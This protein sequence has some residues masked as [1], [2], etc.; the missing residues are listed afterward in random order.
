MD[1]KDISALVNSATQQAM[2]TTALTVID[3]TGVIALGNTVLSSD[4]NTENWTGALF[5]LIGMQI[6]SHRR[7]EPSLM[8]ML[9]ND[10]EWG[11]VV[12]KINISMPEVE[13]D[14]SY[15]I[16]DGSSVDMYKVNKLPV[17]QSLFTTQTPYQIHIS[18]KRQEL[19]EAFRSLN[20]M[21]AFIA[22]H[23]G[24]VQNAINLA[25]ERL[26]MNT[27]NNYIAEV[28]TNA[29]REIKLITEFNA[30]YEETLTADNALESDAFLRYAIRRIK[31]VSDRMVRMTKGV[32]NNGDKERHTPYSMQNLYVASDFA[33]ALETVSLY[34]AFHDNYV[35][36]QGYETVPF[37]QSIETPLDVHVKRASDSADTTVSGVIATLFDYEAL[38]T[39][40]SDQWAAATPLNA[41]GGYINYYWHMKDLY[42][43]DLSENFVSFILA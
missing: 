23:F 43:N 21:G 37:W 10:F 3:D 40:K 32:F 31:I 19:Q 38:G 11:A 27:L 16:T 2:G 13:K 42:F 9:R 33:R 7:Y 22:A 25:L 20:K 12:Q 35:K 36:L 28:N 17:T 14:Q 18:V 24:E 8:R 29:K 26:N 15:D 6:I 4:T 39:Y 30:K 41:A 1:T 5:R 34:Q